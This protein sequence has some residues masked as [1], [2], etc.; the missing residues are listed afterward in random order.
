MTIPNFRIGPL[1]LATALPYIA[2][3]TMLGVIL[4]A[5]PVLTWVERVVLGLIHD[6]LGPN[7]V[8][9]RGLLQPIADGVK[10]FFKEDILPRAVDRHVY[11]L[12]PALAMVP[13]LAASAVIPLQ[14]IALDMG[15][16]HVRNV[17]LVAGDINVGVLWVLGLASLQVY[18]LILGGW[19][20]NNKYSLLG[21][22]RSSAQ[23]ISYEIALGL[24]VMTA[25][26]MSRSM[27][28][29]DV[30][31][32][33]AGGVQHWNAAGLFPFGL[34]AACVFAV[35]A[36][37][38]TNRTPF[39]LPEAES[40][41]VAGFQTEYSS[42]KFAVFFMS[43]YASVVI[44]SAM[45]AILWLGGWHPVHPALGFVPGAVWLLGKVLVL[46]FAFVWV[47]A[48]LPRFRYDALMRFGW[49]RL[50]P[51]ALVALMGAAALD[52]YYTS[53]SAASRIP[54]KPAKP[55]PLMTGPQAT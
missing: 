4:L 42:M 22:L 17:A 45:A 38:E 27:S 26:L 41:L 54:A 13:P 35:A 15:G 53:P 46:I 12:A 19:S 49:K 51:I 2:L 29:V 39:D 30:V 48:T 55:R 40:E 43:E 3:L 16:G 24:A 25:V 20:S 32:Q 9:P 37:A 50:F 18:G 28:L 14:D 8:G 33:Q 23:A 52:A 34:I 36:V 5:V 21:A 31:R 1:D 47:R 44:V 7:R 10:L 6:R 11:Y